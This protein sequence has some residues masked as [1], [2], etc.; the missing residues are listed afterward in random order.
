MYEG[1][2]RKREK[3]HQRA[4]EVEKPWRSSSST[5]FYRWETDAQMKE[6]S[7]PRNIWLLRDVYPGCRRKL[8]FSGVISLSRS[9][10]ALCPKPT[11]GKQNILNLRL[12]QSPQSQAGGCWK[13]RAAG[14]VWT[15]VSGEVC[16][17][18]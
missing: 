14:G 11:A 1:G 12:A 5:F 18:Q 13:S 3:M 7:C 8:N 9:L 6:M 16:G 17:S 4:K 2:W 15:Y 10:F